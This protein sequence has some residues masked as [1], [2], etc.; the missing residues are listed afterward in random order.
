MNPKELSIYVV[1]CIL[2]LTPLCVQAQT[3]VYN[4]KTGI[5]HNASCSNA[6]KCKTCIKIDK[7]QAQ[8]KGARACKKCG[9]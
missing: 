7:K 3:V 5:Y 1:I 6:L 9:G 2:L 4:S 8:E